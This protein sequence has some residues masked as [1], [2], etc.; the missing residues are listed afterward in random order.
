MGRSGYTDDG[1]GSS[2]RL[3]LEFELAYQ[4]QVIEELEGKI[5]AETQ[6]TDEMKLQVE[7]NK[8][9]L[10]ELR[11]LVVASFSAAVML[12]AVFFCLYDKM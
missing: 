7:E 5:E 4:D 1:G 9:K 8:R 12:G 6:K 10:E 3:K 2:L 11:S